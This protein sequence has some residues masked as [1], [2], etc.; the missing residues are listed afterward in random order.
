MNT[1]PYT[2]DGGGTR[3]GRLFC[4][5]CERAAPIDDGLSLET[6]DGR[7]DV[8]CPGCGAVIVSQPQFDSDGA[9]PSLTA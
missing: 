8:T 2:K 4:P 1:T 7:T 9:R 6:H 5:D 3:K